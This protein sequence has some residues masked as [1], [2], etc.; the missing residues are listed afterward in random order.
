M[1]SLYDFATWE[2]LLRLLRT[3][4]APALAAPGGQVAGNIGR[5]SWSVPLPWRQPPPGRA[6]LVSDN[7]DQYDAIERV[8]D[9]LPEAG[10]DD[11]VFV[12]E[13]APDGTTA[14]GLFDHGPAAAPGIGDAHPGA[15]TLVEGAVPEPWRRLPEPVPGA[16]P[17]PSVDLMALERT[18]RERIPDAI[19]ATEEEIAA[20]ESR[21]GRQ[22]P[23]EVRV[24]Y[25]VTRARW[26]D[27]GGD[28]DAAQ[29]VFDAVGFELGAL[30]DL[31]VADPASRRCHWEFAA[32]ETVLTGPDDAVQDLVGSPGWIVLGDS[33]GGD[34]VAVDL[35]PGPRGHLGQIIMLDHEQSIGASLMADSLTSLVRDPDQEWPT[36]GR[37]DKAP[38]AAIVH[39]Q[40][41][42][43][44][45]AAAHAD[46]E[47]L[48]IGRWDGAPFSLAPVIG[49]PRLRTLTAYAG[50][51]AD[52][53]EIAALT[54][55]EFLSLAP[56]DWRVLLDA[57]AVPRTLSA[58]A[59]E[60][61]GGG[62][63]RPTIALANEILALWNRPP[64]TATLVHGDLGPLG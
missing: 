36:G 38:V 5:G 19:G 33:G 13:I 20:V 45:D 40:S 57:G 41:L 53:L 11:V 31:A 52:P 4:H 49:L 37:W 51:L 27:W 15:L 14:L 24:L 34:R 56:A 26:A 22:L 23:E 39:H 21:L 16:R 61:H 7:Q 30:E 46:L 48:R 6:S 2:P 25:R 17:A 50:T 62:D 28:Y 3:A 18:L 42:R 29:C 43:S 10:L 55:L 58:A 47:V 12:L 8:R 35:T 54:G 64:I 44:I 63:P 32:S 60:V 9:A 59:V 1:P